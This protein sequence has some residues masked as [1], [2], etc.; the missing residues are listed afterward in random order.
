LQS[1]D[2]SGKVLPNGPSE[3]YEIAG[4]HRSHPDDCLG[5][6]DRWGCARAI[7]FTGFEHER[8]GRTSASVF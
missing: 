5:S 1:G 2:K 4:H 8:N 6:S 7:A 3:T